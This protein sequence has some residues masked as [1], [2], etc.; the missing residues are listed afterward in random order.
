MAALTG[1]TPNIVYDQLKQAS[2]IP[3]VSAIEAGRDTTLQRGLHRVGL[4]G[5]VFTMTND[6]FSRPLER[7]GVEVS[8]P[9][10]D[11]I[12][13]IQQ[14]IESELE[15]GIVKEETRDQFTAIIRRM[16]KEDGIEQVILGCTELPLLLSDETSPCPA[17]TP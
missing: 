7:S 12:A 3:L 11:E 16:K 10:A 1:N 5:T 14:K 2:P 6:F 4:L 13:L 15:H 9:R 17:S 8:V